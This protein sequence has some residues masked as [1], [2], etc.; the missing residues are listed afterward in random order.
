MKLSR[1]INNEGMFIG[2]WDGFKKTADDFMTDFALNSV[3]REF[4]EPRYATWYRN[5][6]AGGVKWMTEAQVDEKILVY[7][8]RT[9][10]DG[11][12]Q[13]RNIE[14]THPVFATMPGATV[15]VGVTVGEGKFKVFAWHKATRIGQLRSVKDN[16][17]R[18]LINAG[19]ILANNNAQELAKLI[20]TSRRT[21]GARKTPT[22]LDV[23]KRNSFRTPSRHNDSSDGAIWI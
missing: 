13:V 5:L 21:S 2:N 16:G 15:L 22:M 3:H 19:N 7:D 20:K 17:I 6:P 10:H 4:N 23:I 8:T 12:V 9:I 11:R 1:R 18:G 14:F